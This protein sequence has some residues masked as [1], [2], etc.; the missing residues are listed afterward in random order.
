MRWLV[1]FVCLIVYATVLD[2]NRNSFSDWLIIPGVCVFA[3]VIVL[4]F[5]E[6]VT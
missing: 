1:V 3:W 5:L 4:L 2:R 6:G